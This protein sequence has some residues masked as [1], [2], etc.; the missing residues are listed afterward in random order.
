MKDGV[1]TVDNLYSRAN[2]F[3]EAWFETCESRGASVKLSTIAR[4][5][6]VCCLGEKLFDV[7]PD[8]EESDISSKHH[9][10]ARDF[11]T[12]WMEISHKETSLIRPRPIEIVLSD[13]QFIELLDMIASRFA[14]FREGRIT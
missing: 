1:K 8:F 7:S 12:H 14:M 13:L 2:S 11:I 9:D 10:S 3:V 4:G 6:L 5:K